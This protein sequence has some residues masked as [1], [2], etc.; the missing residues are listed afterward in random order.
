MLHE[1]GTTKVALGLQEAGL[2]APG[3]LVSS[4]VSTDEFQAEPG[5]AK[6]TAGKNQGQIIK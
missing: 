5:R 2:R 3:L 4:F 1:V 6:K